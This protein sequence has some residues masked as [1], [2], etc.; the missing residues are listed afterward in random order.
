MSRSKQKLWATEEGGA[1]KQVVCLRFLDL[2]Y[3]SL[4]SPHP[5]P[6]LRHPQRRHRRHPLPRWLPKA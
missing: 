4:S 1:A 3:V 2:T 5:R 6:L